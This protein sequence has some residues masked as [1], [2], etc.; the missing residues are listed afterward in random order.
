MPR[1]AAPIIMA[2]ELTHAFDDEHYG[3][4]EMIE[5]T[6]GDSDRETAIGSLIEGSG[7]VVMSSSPSEDQGR[8][9]RGGFTRLACDE[10]RRGGRRNSRRLPD[11]LLR[12]SSRLH[13]RDRTSFF[14]ETWRDEARGEDRGSRLEFLRPPR[15][16]RR[17]RGE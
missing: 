2:H 5:K 4:D 6:R 9:A 8:H 17:K 11:P 14:A 12:A 10:A 1:A 7:T 16:A 15:L 13:P 3:L